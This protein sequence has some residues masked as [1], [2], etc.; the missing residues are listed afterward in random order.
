MHLLDQTPHHPHDL[1]THPLNSAGDDVDP[2]AEQTGPGSEGS[3]NDDTTINEAVQAIDQEAI[4]IAAA[5]DAAASSSNNNSPMSINTRLR[6]LM[7]ASRTSVVLGKEL[8]NI[9]SHRHRF[10]DSI[11]SPRNPN[12]DRLSQPFLLH[13]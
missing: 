4:R 13:A 7:K 11:H 6:A 8:T 5:A 9:R 3:D 2:T 10:D 12:L 1:I